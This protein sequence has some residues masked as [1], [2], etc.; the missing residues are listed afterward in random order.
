MEAELAK[1]MKTG[2]LLHNTTASVSA[3]AFRR[4][5]PF[6]KRMMMDRMRETTAADRKFRDDEREKERG[7]MRVMAPGV[8]SAISALRGVEAATRARNVERAAAGEVVRRKAAMDAYMAERARSEE[9]ERTARE[10][11]KTAPFL[12]YSDYFE[13]MAPGVDPDDED[14][15]MLVFGGSEMSGWRFNELLTA[16]YEDYTPEELFEVYMGGEKPKDVPKEDRK[17]HYDTLNTM[18][19]EYE[20]DGVD[21]SRSMRGAK[22]P[23]PYAHRAKLARLA[24]TG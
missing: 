14:D 20:E 10:R 4:L 17:A 9:R 8:A 12:K 23:K 21:I 5:S 22:K 16:F 7:R 15:E 13:A 1:V 24:K 19:E 6:G 11:T 2:L 18:R 3:D